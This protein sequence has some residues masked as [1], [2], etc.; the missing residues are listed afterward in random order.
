MDTPWVN[1]PDSH[2]K[3]EPEPVRWLGINTRRQLMHLTDHAE[4]KDRWFA[5]LISKTLDTLFP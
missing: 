1:P 5:P 2:H 4:Y 3:W